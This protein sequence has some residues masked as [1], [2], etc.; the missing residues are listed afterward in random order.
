MTLEIEVPPCTIC[1][2][3]ATHLFANNHNLP[4]CSLYSCEIALI[5]DINNELQ[6]VSEAVKKETE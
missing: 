6:E 2:A 4:L 5:D 3:M 1:G